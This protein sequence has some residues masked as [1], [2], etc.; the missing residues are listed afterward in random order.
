MPG[1]TEAM[2]AQLLEE[3]FGTDDD[4][5]PIAFV[6]LHNGPPGDGTLNVANDTRRMP[7]GLDSTGANVAELV[8]PNSP[9]DTLTHFSMWDDVAAG[10]CIIT[11][12]FGGFVPT[13]C[14]VSSGVIV[15]NGAAFTNGDPVEA[16]PDLT[17][18][19]PGVLAV[20]VQYYVVG[21][22]GPS[23]EL[24]ETSGG[25]AIALGSTPFTFRCQKCLPTAVRSGTPFLIDVGN[26][27][28]RFA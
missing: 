21:V 4:G 14:A 12:P 18:D 23:F 5:N 13:A 7:I 6:Q 20:D 17:A 9:A 16:L 19:L 25:P 11:A 8:W 22:S 15:A 24:A 3:F 27:G 1:L 2:Q 10:S 26:L 28:L